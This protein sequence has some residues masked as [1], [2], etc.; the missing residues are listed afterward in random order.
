MLLSIIIVSWNTRELLDHCLRSIYENPVSG[1]YEIWIVDN[2]S[3]DR[4]VEMVKEKYPEVKL[5]ENQHNPGFAAANNQAIR[6]SEGKYILLLNPDTELKSDALNQLIQFME[7]HPKAG[8]AGAM[9]ILPDGS[10]QQSCHPSLSLGRELWRLFHLDKLHAIGSYEMEKWDKQAA[11]EVDGLQGAAL[12][13][14][15]QALAQVG[16]LDEDYFM[17]T[18]EVDLCYRLR[19][20]GWRLYWLPEAKVLHYCGQST[21]LVM[22]KMF[23]ALYESRIKYFRKHNGPT[24]AK[25]YKLILTAAALARIVLSP[26]PIIFMPAHREKNI[27][28]ASRYSRLLNRLPRM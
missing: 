1:D 27:T 22:E 4:S 25:L 3:S 12:I 21:K 10:V 28:L 5:I 18:E 9:L 15:R 23:M 24:A 13:L 7:Q 11:R 14:R 16:L 19:K 6:V 8:G 17:Y 2:S 26:V 20:A